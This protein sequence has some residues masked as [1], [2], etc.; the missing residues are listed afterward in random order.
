MRILIVSDRYPPH[1]LGGYET[2]AAGAARALRGANHEVRVLTSVF[3]IGRPQRD[4]DTWRV[5]HRPMDTPSLPQQALW[6]LQD[7]AAVRRCLRDF[8]PEAVYAFNLVQLFPSVHQALAEGPQEVAYEF[9][10]SVSL[11][12]HLRLA[13]EREAVW[14]NPRGGL[15]GCLRRFVRAGARAVD[16]TWGVVPTLETLRLQRAIFC[17]ESVRDRC[18]LAGLP[19]R[20]ATVVYNP[21]D[22]RDFATSRTSPKDAFRVLFAGRLVAEKGAAETIEACRMLLDRGQSVRLSI[23]GPAVFPIE[24]S[25][26]LRRVAASS[27]LSGRVTF[28]GNV[29]HSEMSAVYSTHDVLVFPSSATEGMPMT[30]LEAM[31]AGLPVVSTLTGGTAEILEPER[32]CLPLSLPVQ[33]AEIANQIERL[34]SD[35]GLVSQLVTEARRFVADRCA[36]EDVARRTVE[37]LRAGREST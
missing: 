13:E 17:S 32:S 15:R 2:A 34:A 7:L 25:E 6:E 20:D 18:R 30:L 31:A 11:L 23:A 26:S 22:L 14:S 37:F 1:S 28:L 29:P 21:L 27:S 3:G 12:A 16:A 9:Q 4:D 35:H 10:D 36:P 8:K 5:L 33:P 24:Y 19:I